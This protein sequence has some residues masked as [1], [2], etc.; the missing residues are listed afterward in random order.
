MLYAIVV[1]MTQVP[2]IALICLWEIHEKNY[3]QSEKYKN[4][5]LTSTCPLIL[6]LKSLNEAI[7]SKLIQLKLTPLAIFIALLL[8]GFP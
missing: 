2:E 3:I 4:A 5:K 1:Y 7:L 6:S 8:V